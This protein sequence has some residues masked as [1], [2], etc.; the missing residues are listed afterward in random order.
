MVVHTLLSSASLSWSQ[1]NPDQV[2]TYV[3]M[4]RRHGWWIKAHE[5]N[6]AICDILYKD[7]AREKNCKE[8]D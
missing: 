7:F 4:I 5:I 2:G 8:D 1:S 3:G 6:C